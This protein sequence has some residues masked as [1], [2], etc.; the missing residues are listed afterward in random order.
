MN[1]YSK[2][3]RRAL[4]MM[5]GSAL[6]AAFP[7]AARA[8]DKAPLT[9]G[10]QTS[11][12]GA[13]GMVAEAEKLFEKAGAN[14]KVHKFDSGR[15]VR[16][17]MVAGRIDLGSLGAAPFVVGAAKG[18]MGALG[19]VAYAGGTLAV[20]AS[21][22]SGMKSVADLKGKKVASQLGSETDHVFQNKIAPHFGLK[23]GA[24][25]QVVNVKFHD[26][27]SALAG[28]SVDAF[29][30]VE[31]YP[32]IAE[33]DGLGTILTDYSKFDIVPLL[34]AV[35]RSV[36]EKRGDDLVAF[37]KG[38]LAAVKLFKDQPQRV[39][40]IVL[41]F[42]KSQGYNVSDEVIRRALVHMNVTPEYVPGLKAYLT[43]IAQTLVKKGQIA[44]VPDWDKV[45]D[46]RTLQRAAQ[47]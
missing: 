12:W 42:Y 19:T 28:G 30:G 1:H 24:D 22:K 34:L 40:A 8:Q 21:K 23:P 43:D 41:N 39:T 35:S 37:M 6:A 16:D 29:A 26:H 45:L 44:A 10:I 20:V 9:L 32:S 14:V 33:V 27:V 17:A 3:R 47:A 11:T 31:P 46:Q 36:L 7:I 5:G 4:A 25:F 13:V 2:S 18:D 38:W 15:A